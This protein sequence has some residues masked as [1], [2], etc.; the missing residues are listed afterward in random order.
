MSLEINKIYYASDKLINWINKSSI[1][2]I[3]ESIFILFT[4]LMIND[5]FNIFLLIVGIAGFVFYSI[6]FLYSSTIRRSR[7][8]NQT[9]KSIDIN[10]EKFSIETFESTIPFFKKPAVKVVG[11]LTETRLMKKAYPII[12]R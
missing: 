5:G 3:Y 4:S 11:N 6:L 7:V 8:I 1:S 10:N 9:I 2:S 12:D